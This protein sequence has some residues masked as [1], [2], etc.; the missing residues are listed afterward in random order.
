MDRGNVGKKLDRHIDRHVQHVVD[1]LPFVFD[2]ER[3]PII[4][5]ASAGLAGDID[6][7]QEIHLDSLHS[8]TPALLAA[9]ALHVEGEAPRLEPSDLGRRASIRTACGCRK[10]RS[11]RSPDCSAASDR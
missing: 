10:R 9:A 2:F 6:I 3:L 1:V 8:G 11:N 4:T 7:G 5:V